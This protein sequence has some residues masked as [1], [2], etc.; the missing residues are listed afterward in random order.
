MASTSYPTSSTATVT[1][2]E[3][4]LLVRDYL[5]SEGFS[6]TL[7]QFEAEAEGLLRQG[8]GGSNPGL[9]VDLGVARGLKPLRGVV[10]EYLG[11]AEEW[12]RKRVLGESHPLAARILCVLEDFANDSNRATSVSGDGRGGGDR[13]PGQSFDTAFTPSPHRALPGGGDGAGSVYGQHR[14]QSSRAQGRNLFAE[15]SGRE[16]AG[17]SPTAPTPSPLRRK[18]GTPRKRNVVAQ[19]NSVDDQLLPFAKDLAQRINGSK[20]GA[21]D[22]ISEDFLTNLE[23][24][25]EDF[26]FEHLLNSLNPEADGASYHPLQ[27]SSN[28]A[29]DA[30][31]GQANQYH[32]SSK[33]PRRRLSDYLKTANG[34]D[35]LLNSIKY[36]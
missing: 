15:T 5:S 4:S 34:V 16:A 11:L 19:P 9:R 2:A 10:S 28:D 6:R 29:V 14:L 1:S 26:G 25:P 30:P 22:G 33:R 23:N 3:L 7:E 13:F 12:K 27:P 31:A 36:N 20:G 24:L 32:P 17:Q 35:N 18:K 21:F 8:S